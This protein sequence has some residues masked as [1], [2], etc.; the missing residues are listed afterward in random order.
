MRSLAGLECE[1]TV[2]QRDGMNNWLVEKS[3]RALERLSH[4][5]DYVREDKEIPSASQEY[6]LDNIENASSYILKILASILDSNWSIEDPK[7]IQKHGYNG[8][9]ALRARY[10]GS[11]SE[12]VLT[13]QQ[14]R[15][16]INVYLEEDNSKRTEIYDL[17]PY[18]LI[19]DNRL[20]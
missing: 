19:N 20:D 2:I 15:N 8:Y 7:L 4:L 18:A 11:N 13:W 1:S 9:R 5:V 12:Y 17:L 14:F 6:I 10:D 3:D 16:R